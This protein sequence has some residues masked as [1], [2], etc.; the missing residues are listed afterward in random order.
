MRMTPMLKWEE[1]PIRRGEMTLWALTG[2]SL[3]SDG[4]LDI[5]LPKFLPGHRPAARTTLGEP[6]VWLP[7]DTSEAD[8]RQLCVAFEGMIA[9]AA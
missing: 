2:S 6:R 8:R 3:P 7:H 9:A 4:Q 1:L 5:L